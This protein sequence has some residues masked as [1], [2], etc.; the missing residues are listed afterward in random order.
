[1]HT[2]TGI[3][4]IFTIIVIC[5]QAE[6]LFLLIEVKFFINSFIFFKA[7]FLSSECDLELPPNDCR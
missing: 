3:I 6:L 7:L 2:R 5:N 4:R 1:M